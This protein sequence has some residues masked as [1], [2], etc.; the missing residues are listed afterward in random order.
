MNYATYAVSFLPFAKVPHYEIYGTND[1]GASRVHVMDDRTGAPAEF[2][3][4][5]EAKKVMRGL[6]RAQ[7]PAQMS[8]I[9]SKA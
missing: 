1:G 5:K 3:D 7:I 8:L 4:L 9:A 2:L 6:Y